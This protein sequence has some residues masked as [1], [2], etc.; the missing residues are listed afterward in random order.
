MKWLQTRRQQIQNLWRRQEPAFYAS[1][2]KQL[3][4]DKRC[5]DCCKLNHLKN[6]KKT[7]NKWMW[8]EMAPA[9]GW[10]RASNQNIYTCP[11]KLIWK[12]TFTVSS[13]LAHAHIFQAATRF[14]VINKM[15]SENW[16]KKTDLPQPSLLNGLKSGN[17]SVKSPINTWVK[18]IRVL[19][20][21]FLQ[22]DIS[23]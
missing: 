15:R 6:W 4:G 12:M 17:L 3:V 1:S 7:T 18:Y 9:A 8:T 19:N 20:P 16:N 21:C 13:K 2:A 11:K 5:F 14:Q 10:I 22:S 23:S